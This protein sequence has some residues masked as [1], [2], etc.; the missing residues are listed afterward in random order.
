MAHQ[1]TIFDVLVLAFFLPAVV[2]VVTS[3]V[4]CSSD[5]SQCA[6]SNNPS[7]LSGLIQMR[8]E[9]SQDSDLIADN[10]ELHGEDFN[11][12]ADLADDD[13]EAQA[14]EPK[15]GKR[16]TNSCEDG[17]VA[18]SSADECKSAAQVLGKRFVK[19][20]HWRRAPKGCLFKGRIVFYNTHK[21]GKTNMRWAP[22]CTKLPQGA[23]QAPAT[24]TQA[25]ATTTQAPATIPPPQANCTP[26]VYPSDCGWTTHDIQKCDGMF[27]PLFWDS[28]SAKA[29]C[30]ELGPCRCRG[31]TCRQLGALTSCT[32]RT[33]TTP[34]RGWHTEKT[35]MPNCPLLGL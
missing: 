29:K 16:G 24:T 9:R 12:D 35:Y 30:L 5:D 4:T 11:D 33:C 2:Q 25:P 21:T 13:V 20:G 34:T 6:V 3:D 19:T 15:P 27:G 10:E 17:T 31:V 7:D 32:M 14:S 18:M 1:R 22:L 8:V 28:A 26:N 23:A